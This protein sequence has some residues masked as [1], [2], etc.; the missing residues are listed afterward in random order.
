MVEQFFEATPD[1]LAFSAESFELF[2]KP[3]VFIL[4][5]FPGFLRFGEFFQGGVFLLA[6]FRHERHGLLDSFFQPAE[7]VDFLI[8]NER[9]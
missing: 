9:H 4:R 8:L 1:L 5:L 2:S 7:R 6:E 3:G